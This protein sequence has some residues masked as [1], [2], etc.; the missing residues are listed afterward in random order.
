[1]TINGQIVQDVIIG[2]TLVG[3]VLLYLK[4]HVP[5]QTIKNLE[6]ANDSYVKLDATRQKSIEALELKVKEIIDRH[7]AEKLEWTQAVAE[8]QGQIKVYKEL[9]LR[10]LADGIAKVVDISKEN[11]ISNQHIL[12]TLRESAGT[13]SAEKNDGGLLVKTK[14]GKPLGVK[15]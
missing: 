12:E 15:M 11:A 1:M 5:Q 6:A 13:H 8:L 10:E 4:G 3:G 7:T 2:I 9:P 14:D